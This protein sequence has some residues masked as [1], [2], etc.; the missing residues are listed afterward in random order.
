M[1]DKLVSIKDEEFN[2]PCG[3]DWGTPPIGVIK[4]ST[5]KALSAQFGQ[6]FPNHIAHN[7]IQKDIKKFI[8]DSKY[9]IL[10]AVIF[11]FSDFCFMV[12]EFSGKIWKIAPCH[13]E[14]TRE[15]SQAEAKEKGI[16]HWGMCC[17]VQWC[18]DCSKHI[19]TYDSSD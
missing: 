11:Y 15:L 4:E 9:R 19:A 6:N 18:N 17:H 13:H 10:D 5:F 12:E 7:Q 14:H 8:P 16:Y 2:H 3:Y 1:I